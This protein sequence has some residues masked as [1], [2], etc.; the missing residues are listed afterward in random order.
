MFFLILTGRYRYT[1]QRNDLHLGRVGTSF[2]Y[3]TQNGV[4][5]NTYEFFISGILHLIFSD[6]GC[7]QI[8]ETAESETMDK[9]GLLYITEQNRQKAQLMRNFYYEKDRQKIN[10]KISE[11]YL[12][13]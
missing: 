7:L 11:L 12:I 10:E 9:G 4:Q 13:R 6:H 8:T 2:H 3:A 5:F 1:G